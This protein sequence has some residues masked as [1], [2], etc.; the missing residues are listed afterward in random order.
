VTAESGAAKLWHD[1]AG[2]VMRDELDE[3]RACV[4]DGFEWE[5][6]GRFPYAGQYQGVEGLATL[7]KGVRQG[8]GGTFHMTPEL[9]FGDEDAAVVIGRVTS[10]RAG[11]TL[12]ARNVFIV[13]CEGGKIAHGWTVPVDQYAYDEFWE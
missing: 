1:M 6:M 13:Q 3:A 10:S 7:F 9:T 11:K 2:A 12:D 5:V 4:T 8:S